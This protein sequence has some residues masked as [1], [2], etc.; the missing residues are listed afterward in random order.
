M[1]QKL[2]IEQFK[3][4]ARLPSFAV[5]SRYD[6]HLKLDLCACAFTGTVN[7]NLSIIQNT[8]FIVLNA[9]R[10]NVHEVLF[11]TSHNQVSMLDNHNQ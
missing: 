7:I 5:P 8:N 9:A 3:G 10:L 11:A 1:V 6:L 4:Q 2:N